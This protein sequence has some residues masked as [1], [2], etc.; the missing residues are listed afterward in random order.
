LARC[1]TISEADIVSEDSSTHPSPQAAGREWLP[2]LLGL[3]SLY[4][5]TFYGL[6]TTIWQ[7]EDYAHG[8]IILAIVLWL[9][10]DKRRILLSAPA[11]PATAAGLALLTFGLLVYIVGHSQKISVLEIGALI[12]ILAGVLLALRGTS[13]LSGY[14]FMLLFIIY[15]VP[16][17]GVFVDGVT[18]PLKI[19]VSEI[20]EEILYK[21]GYPIAR[22]GVML[23]IGQYRLLVAD[24]C[25]GINSMFSLSA[26]GVLYLY[27]TER[28][29][30][31][32]NGLVLCSLLP[33]AFCANI[34]RVIILVLVTYKLG[35][36]AG[37]GF[38]HSFSGMVMFAV[39]L[40][41]IF[42]LDKTLA[43]TMT[44]RIAAK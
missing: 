42:F 26:V 8:P 22:D 40:I 12:P 1:S 27:L 36:A 23:T 28:K 33:I 44:A 29:S 19:Y 32:H 11:K 43:R 2:V 14:W 21:S 10:W 18:G 30:W 25:S 39:A 38:I 5:S 34:V 20:S 13:A 15:L 9:I 31:L 4:T 17:P 37:Q 16:L 7:E 6:A 24:A 3:L 35:N 41:F